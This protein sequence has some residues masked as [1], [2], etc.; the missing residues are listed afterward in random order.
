MN[1]ISSIYRYGFHKLL[2]L[3]LKLFLFICT[4]SQLISCA[5]TIPKQIYLTNASLSNISKVA[6]VSSANVPEASY[7]INS[8]DAGYS[9]YTVLFGL[10]VFPAMGLEA[11]IRSGVDQEHAA[12]ITEQTDL[13][14]LE[15]KLVQSFMEPLKKS[16]RFQTTEYMKTKNLDN[17]QLLAEGYDAI[18]RLSLYKISIERTVGSIT[19]LYVSARGQMEGLRSKRILW[20]REEIV[21]SSKSRSLDY[22]RQN[23]L[24]EIDAIIERAGLNMA[25]DFEYLK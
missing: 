19:S 25:Y 5:S 15:E 21:R 12:R 8:S 1:T 2:H 9:G 20:E 17:D 24:N 3:I 4:A 10:I 6:V 23:G 16:A 18:I 22:Y 7:S 11:A 14:Y 13:G